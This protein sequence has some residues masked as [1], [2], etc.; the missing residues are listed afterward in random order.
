MHIDSKPT[1]TV[2]NTVAS[3]TTKIRPQITNYVNHRIVGTTEALWSSL[4][5]ALAKRLY[6][7]S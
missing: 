7:L 2:Y 1:V 3:T 5:P 6:P 4:V